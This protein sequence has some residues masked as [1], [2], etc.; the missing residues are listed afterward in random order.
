MKIGFFVPCYINELYPGVAKA[1]LEILE[2]QGLDVEYP[3]EQTCCGQPMA[4]SGC[5]KDLKD[6]AVRF[7]D[8][9]KQYDYIVGPSG[10]CVSMVRNHYAQFLEGMPGFDH[11]RE[12]TYELCE[13][14]HD[15][16]DVKSFE[17]LSFPYKVGLHNSCHGHRGLKLGSASEL[18][19]SS[20]N[21][22][23]TLLGSIPD[24]TLVELKRKDECCGFGG[25]F[26][27]GEKDV[28]AFMGNDR[29]DD[30]LT[31]GAEIMTGADISCLMHMDGLIQR[32]GKPLRVMHIAEILNGEAPYG[33]R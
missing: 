24:I 14:L 4:N 1:S 19:I 13:F 6:L 20:F 27:V 25:T 26:A 2:R 11:L 12:R 10:S 33:S 22:L 32:Q 9:F 30:H 8:I 5:T 31:A 17:H 29:I 15:V 16:L 23:E 3:L 18:N 7:L 21:K 28:S